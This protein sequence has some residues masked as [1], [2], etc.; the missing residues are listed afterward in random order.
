MVLLLAQRLLNTVLLSNSIS[1]IALS[2]T[3]SDNFLSIFTGTTGVQLIARVLLPSSV[4]G[5]FVLVHTQCS[6][7][8]AII[9][10]LDS[11]AWP[12]AVPNDFNQLVAKSIARA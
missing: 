1:G 8:T 12:L 5:M 9:L 3:Q 6:Y 10:D 2:S 4:S 11:S 7:H